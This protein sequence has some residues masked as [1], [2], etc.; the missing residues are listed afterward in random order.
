MIRMKRKNSHSRF[1][2][3]L[4]VIAL[5]VSATQA[6]AETAEEIRTIITEEA[7]K[8]SVPASLAIA[9]ARVESG[10]RSDHQGADGGRGLFQVSPDMARDLGTDP[11]T[12]WQP[13]TNSRVALKQL[14]RLLNRADGRWDTAL[15]A[16]S[17][18]H[19]AV[20]PNSKQRYVADVL[21]W[22]RRYAERLALTDSVNAR[23]R[24][25]LMGDSTPAQNTHGNDS[26]GHDNWG[27]A[28]PAEE[29]E[30]ASAGRDQL[31]EAHMEP[32]PPAHQPDE[33]DPMLD[34]DTDVEGAVRIFRDRNGDRVEITVYEEEYEVEPPVW[35]QPPPPR[36][37]APPPPPRWRAQ[38]WQ[39][40]HPPRH[41]RGPRWSPRKARQLKRRARRM[42][43]GRARRHQW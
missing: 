7:R 8:T 33:I 17:T 19:G 1:F 10:L 4:S 42:A 40:P 39:R 14:E 29:P 41:F 28:M 20:H 30:I 26:R 23:R 5:C 36:W 16:Y 27:T 9:V 35:H 12:L 24:E 34:D 2:A 38:R 32:L 18:R 3:A 31:P 6:I 11:R 13:R 43:Q 15:Q 21:G 22:E 37:A 25:V